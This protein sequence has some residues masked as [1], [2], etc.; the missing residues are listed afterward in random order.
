MTTAGWPLRGG[1][2][3]KK[4]TKI[5]KNNKKKTKKTIRRSM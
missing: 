3:G 4:N 2:R 1:G 5:P